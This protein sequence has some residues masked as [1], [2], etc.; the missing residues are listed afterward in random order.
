MLG[1]AGHRLGQVT[2][3][4]TDEADRC[5]VEPFDMRTGAAVQH[6]DLYVRGSTADA[7]TNGVDANNV[8][9]N[10]VRCSAHATGVACSVVG[11]PGRKLSLLLVSEGYILLPVGCEPILLNPT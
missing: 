11:E 10:P 3:R 4:L 2:E 6:H 5:C 9:W 8:A 1:V 7:S